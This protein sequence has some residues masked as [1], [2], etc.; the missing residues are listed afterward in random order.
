M[1]DRRRF[2]YDGP[3]LAAAVA[4]VSAVILMEMLR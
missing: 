1:I 3:L 2:L 4:V